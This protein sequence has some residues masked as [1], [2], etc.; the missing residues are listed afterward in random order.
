MTITRVFVSLP[1]VLAL[2][3]FPAISRA[4]DAPASKPDP[5][6]QKAA[7]IDPQKEKDIRTLLDLSGAAKLGM[8]VI[9]Q[10]ITQMRQIH[11]D[12]PPDF[13]DAFKKE[14][15]AEDFTNLVV[16][17]YAKHFSDDEV[18]ELIKF[19]KSPIGQKLVREQPQMM[20]E[21]MIVGQQ[22]GFQLG[23]KIARRLKEK[24]YV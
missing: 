2:T 17:I 4:E 14:A 20:R 19:Y 7:A 1:L 13:W 10:M 21:S 9:D 15:N 3:G 22:W 6:D 8:Q 24:G 5:G 11:P 18:K 23:Q 16:P 12:V